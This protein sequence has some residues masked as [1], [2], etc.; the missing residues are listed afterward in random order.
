[1][2]LKTK[3]APRNG[4]AVAQ[5]VYALVQLLAKIYQNEAPSVKRYPPRNRF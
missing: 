3:T 2:V 1:M 4:G 5:T